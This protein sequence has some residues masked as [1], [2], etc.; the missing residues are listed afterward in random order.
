VSGAAGRRG[1]RAGTIGLAAALLLAAPGGMDGAAERAAPPPDDVVVI[2]LFLPAAGP[3]LAAAREV[4]R[5]AALAVERANRTGGVA[6]RPLRLRSIPSDRLWDAGSGG[7][8]RLVFDDH[9]AAVVGALDGRS[10]H[11]AEQVITRARGRAVFV[12]PWATEAS[13]TR[14]RVPWFFSVVPDDRRQAAVL[15]QEIYARRGVVRAALCVGEG[16][17]AAAAA[18]AFERAAP[19]GGSERFRAGDRRD[20]ERLAAEIDAGAV[21]AIVLPPAPAAAAE[22]ALWLRARGASDVPLFGPLALADPAFR[23][24]AGEAAGMVSIVGPSPVRTAVAD[25]VRRAYRAAHGAAPGPPALYG[26]DA[27]AAVVAALRAV[28][29]GAQADLPQALAATSLPGATGRVSFDGNRGRDGAP[30]QVAPLPPAA[31]GLALSGP[32]EMRA[33]AGR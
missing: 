28:A 33:E 12:T 18:A 20:R 26:H 17:D 21:G 9:V 14:I 27:V 24:A 10:A 31:A 19:S 25:E 32:T 22:L 16:F 5:G 23:E 2:G 4:E 3:A 29:R 1:G 15:A 30:L 7:L 11:L 6:G 13:A 8:A